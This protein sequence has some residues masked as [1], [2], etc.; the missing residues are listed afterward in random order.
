MSKEIRLWSSTAR[1]EIGWTSIL[2]EALRVIK[3]MEIKVF[4]LLLLLNG[5]HC[6]F[7]PL[8]WR[9]KNMEKHFARME[10]IFRV[11][12]VSKQVFRCHKFLS[13]LTYF[14]AIFI[15]ISKNVMEIFSIEFS[16]KFRKKAESCPKKFEFKWRKESQLL[17]GTWNFKL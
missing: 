6:R 10:K 1:R 3:N 11:K 13:F 5:P 15:R 17:V 9:E 12:L 14:T 8:S 16:C 4:F 2:I 7:S